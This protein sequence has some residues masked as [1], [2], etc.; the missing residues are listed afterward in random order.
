MMNQNRGG[1]SGTITGGTGF[2]SMDQGGRTWPSYSAAAQVCYCSHLQ[3]DPAVM[4]P[5][6][7]GGVYHCHHHWDGDGDGDGEACPAR[8]S[9]EP[10]PFCADERATAAEEGASGRSRGV[11]GEEREEQRWVCCRKATDQSAELHLVYGV[12]H[13]RGLAQAWANQDGPSAAASDRLERWKAPASTLITYI[14]TERYFPASA[15]ASSPLSLP[16][17]LPRPLSRP[18]L[19]PLRGRRRWC[20]FG[21][22]RSALPPFLSSASASSCIQHLHAHRS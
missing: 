15:L 10:A 9:S 7:V 5:M 2:L 14:F 1:S 18:R 16:L 19:R 17:P 3:A 21:C 6:R 4:A 11:G 20:G 8:P 12:W 22:F 13:C